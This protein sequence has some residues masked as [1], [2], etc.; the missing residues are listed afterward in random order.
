MTITA[1]LD[2]APLTGGLKA[3]ATVARTGVIARVACQQPD[4]LE[5]RYPGV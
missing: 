1:T 4:A 2:A 3:I 5:M